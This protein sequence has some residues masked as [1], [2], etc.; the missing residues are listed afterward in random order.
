MLFYGRGI[1]PLKAGCMTT[2]VYTSWVV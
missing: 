1:D 2:V